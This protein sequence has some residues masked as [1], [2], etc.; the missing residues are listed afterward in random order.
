MTTSKKKILSHAIKAAVLILAFYFIYRRINNNENLRQFSVLVKNVDPVAVYETLALIFIL[1]LVNWTL[2]ALKWKYLIRSM[3][4]ISVWKAVESVFCGLTWAIFTPNRIGEYGGRILFLPPRKRIHGIFA[5]A[6]GAFG[7]NIITNV[8]GIIGLLWFLYTFSS[9]DPIVYVGILLIATLFII[10][11]VTFYF[12]VRWLVALLNRI[13]F[14]RKYERFFSIIGRY[15]LPELVNIIFF[16]LARF[17][18]FSSQYYF[19]IHLLIPEISLLNILMMVFILFFI[20]SALPSLD[21]L[22]IGVRGATATYFFSYVTSQEIAI[23]A[24][25]SC[26]WFVNLIIPA[27]LGSAFVLKLN[28]FGRT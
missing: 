17:A 12:H 27:M 18:V 16:S 26:I 1:M 19:I 13:P 23:I 9:L 21:L 5:M 28:F 11:L 15:K 10:L 24:A 22:D 25:V 4:Q 14:L 3:E 20:Q 6:I 8:F 2:E 7:Q